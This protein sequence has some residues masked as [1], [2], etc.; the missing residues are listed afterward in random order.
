[1]L[2]PIA[3][4]AMSPIP[5]VSVDA[6]ARATIRIERPAVANSNEWENSPH[7]REIIVRGE[8]G[9]PVLVRLIEYQ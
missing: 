6:Q 9:E 2:L 4:V 3:S 8:H 1:M 7:R 5:P